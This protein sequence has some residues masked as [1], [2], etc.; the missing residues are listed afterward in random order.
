M[1]IIK[2][3]KTDFDI[4]VEAYIE[5]KH[6]LKTLESKVNA[7]KADIISDMAGQ[8]EVI[9]DYHKVTNKEQI[10]DGVD[11]AKLKK[12]FPEAYSACFNPSIFPVLRAK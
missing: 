5:E 2:K 9:T 8:E 10:R 11:L 3:E 12:E 4:K 6:N 1:D 7:L